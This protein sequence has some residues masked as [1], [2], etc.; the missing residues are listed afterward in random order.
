MKKS[1]LRI[2]QICRQELRAKFWNEVCYEFLEMKWKLP[3]ACIVTAVVL[4]WFYI[5]WCTFHAIYCAV[6][7]GKNF[8]L[9]LVDVYTRQRNTSGRSYFAYK[10]PLVSHHRP[11]FY[12]AFSHSSASTGLL[13][14][15]GHKRIQ[16]A[17]PEVKFFSDILWV[18]VSAH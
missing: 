1:Q 12:R 4:D 14:L 15:R 10:Q 13:V 16:T 3:F 9:F 5:P 17:V 2:K 8:Y 18:Q 7:A 11:C 6:L